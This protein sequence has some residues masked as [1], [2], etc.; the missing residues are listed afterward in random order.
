MAIDASGTP[1]VAYRDKGN[2][3]KA[4]VMRFNGSTWVNVGTPG[5]SA[6]QADYT[7][8]AIDASG[9]PYVVYRDSA[10]SKKASV[11]K[12]NGS[13]WT[14]VGSNPVSNTTMQ[15]CDIAITPAGEPIIVYSSF[16]YAKKY[17][18]VVSSVDELSVKENNLVLYP[19]PA[20][21]KVNI[22]SS[23]KIRNIVVY[24]ITGE[25]IYTTSVNEQEAS[26]D[27]HL[28]ASGIY[29]IQLETTNGAVISKKLVIE[30]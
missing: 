22:Q 13:A 10:N 19:N 3:Y 18:C 2:S 8:I 9:T 11:M 17:S 12:F 24:S 20:N 15:Y 6:G 5:F 30:R 28:F 4:T 21:N 25:K 27:T 1:Y 23:E 7:S 16:L 14:N 26:I 29:F